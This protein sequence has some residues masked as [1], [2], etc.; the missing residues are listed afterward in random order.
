VAF[1]QMH[2]V[3]KTNNPKRQHD[4]LHSKKGQFKIISCTKECRIQ[5]KLEKDHKWHDVDDEQS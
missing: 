4:Q 2:L 5:R 3:V 1:E